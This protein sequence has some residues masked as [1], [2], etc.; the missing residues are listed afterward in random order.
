MRH[1]KVY[2]CHRYQSSR[3]GVQLVK[4]SFITPSDVLDSFV[5]ICLWFV[6]LE[7]MLCTLPCMNI[8]W[9]ETKTIMSIDIVTNHSKPELA[10]K[11]SSPFASQTGCCIHTVC[12]FQDI[13]KDTTVK[14]KKLP[15]RHPNHPRRAALISSSFPKGDTDAQIVLLTEN[16]TLWTHVDVAKRPH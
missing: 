16:M 1:G 10:K 9:P 14:G 4:Q 6:L 7:L 3:H 8:G 5:M 11:T 13:N 15:T 12:T 2:H